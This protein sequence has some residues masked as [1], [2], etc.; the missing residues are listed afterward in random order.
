[1][2]KEQNSAQVVGTCGQLTF[3]NA[4]SSF[5]INFLILF[6]LNVVEKRPHEVEVKIHYTI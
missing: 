1:M 5:E 4:Y 3:M 2:T 6:S